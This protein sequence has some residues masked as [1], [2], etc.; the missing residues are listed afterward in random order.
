M[1]MEYFTW[2]LVHLCNN[3]ETFMFVMLGII[4]IIRIQLVLL[5]RD[6][7]FITLY[8]LIKVVSIS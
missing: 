2:M 1:I 8:K 3:S 6:M 5:L 7:L 4:I